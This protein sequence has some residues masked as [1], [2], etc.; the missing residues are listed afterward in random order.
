MKK[1]LFN[2]G[3]SIE[4]VDKETLKYSEKEFSVLIWVDYY[5]IGFFKYGRVIKASSIEKWNTEAE[6]SIELISAN[7]KNEI[8]K[9]IQLYYES[10]NTKYRI[11]H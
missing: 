8:I 3:S 11:E 1:K 4:W 7:K 6:S 5:K 2:D 9:K 10:L